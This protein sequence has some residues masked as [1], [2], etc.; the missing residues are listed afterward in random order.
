MR[1][2]RDE[3]NEERR[4]QSLGAIRVSSHV[5]SSKI[6]VAASILTAL[7]IV[8]AYSVEVSRKAVT[9]GIIVPQFGTV[10]IASNVSGYVQARLTEEGAAVKAG[11]PLFVIVSD[12]ATAEGNASV[13]I[14]TNL[15]ER[16]TLIDKEKKNRRAD[17]IARL[18]TTQT[19]LQMLD[20][21]VSQLESEI[22]LAEQRTQLAKDSH[23]RFSGLEKEG[24]V[25]AL[26]TQS[27]LEEFLDAQS[28]V[29]GLRR[30]L[31]ATQKERE[32][33]KDQA[34]DISFQL[35]DTLIQLDKERAQVNR[36]LYDNET[37][38]GQIIVAPESG[39]ISALYISRGAA[40]QPGQNVAAIIP[41]PAGGKDSGW[42]FGELYASTKT[43]GFAKVDDEVWI[44]FS[45]L[46]YQKYG[47]S[48]AT[49]TNIS[50]SPIG[51]QELP[52]GQAQALISAA[53]TNEPLYRIKVKI[54]KADIFENGTKLKPGMTLQ[55]SLVQESRAIWEWMLE[56]LLVY[57]KRESID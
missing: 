51:A 35:E 49:I 15:A 29:H 57:R 43:A 39:T 25:S 41:T 31:L 56:P 28:K 42:L 34:K 17:S 8:F 54:K 23:A 26:Q 4:S 16:Q 7:Y 12:R 32:S 14:A 33:V 50:E 3:V 27:K 30:A 18:T 24:Y 11:D 53:N 45:A 19:R 13:L 40:I 52:Q 44:Q 36:E 48:K 21:E 22:A 38:K 9:P 37:R 6:V 10:Q 5:H 55:A 2:F 20:T 46:P 47:M 1:L